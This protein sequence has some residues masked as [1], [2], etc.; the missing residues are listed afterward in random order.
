MKQ[1]TAGTLSG[2]VIWVI[3]IGILGSCILPMFFAIGS[4]TSFSRYAINTTGKILCPTGSTPTSYS[5]QT[6]THDSEGFPQPTT[7][8]ELHC[9]DAGGTVVKTDP[10]TYALLWDGIFLLIGLIATVGLSFLLAAP[11][12]A[13]IGRMFNRAGKT[14]IAANIEP[15]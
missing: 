7:A 4:V 15:R 14:N 9:V 1:T 13:L 3:M 2:C 12:G 8:Y 11:L 5:Y 6:T 10:F